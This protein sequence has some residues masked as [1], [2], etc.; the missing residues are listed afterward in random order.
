MSN[1]DGNLVERR[2]FDNALG[3]NGSLVICKFLGRQNSVG[4]WTVGLS[5]GTGNVPPP[6]VNSENAATGGSI[7]ESG[8]PITG[9]QIFPNL[10][11]NI[12]TAGENANKLVLSGTATAGKN[13]Q[14]EMVT[15]TV[16]RLPPSQTP[17]SSYVGE[18]IY[19]LTATT[20]SSPISLALGQQVLVTVV[21]SFS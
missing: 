3:S 13:G 17:Q 2:E 7:V 11:V 4:A 16:Y 14:I 9:P 8:Y 18:G 15:T 5:G 6:F 12:P 1:P 19:V 21:I 10:T 20:L